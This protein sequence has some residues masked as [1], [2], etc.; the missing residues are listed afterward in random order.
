MA[1]LSGGLPRHAFLRE[2]VA[3]DHTLARLQDLLRLVQT[4][5]APSSLTSLSVIPC[6]APHGTSEQAFSPSRLLTGEH[7]LRIPRGD[8]PPLMGWSNAC[9]DQPHMSA[10]HSRDC[11]R[12]FL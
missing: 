2:G 1:V 8:R 12:I 5:Y 11:N 10:C 9:A 7:C 4:P 3:E 6:H